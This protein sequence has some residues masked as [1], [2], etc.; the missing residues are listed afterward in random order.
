MGESATPYK[1]GDGPSCMA[2]RF[3]SADHGF[4]CSPDGKETS[5]IIFKAGAARDGYFDNNNI[6]TQATKH[7][8]LCKKY[9][10][11][12]EH[13]LIYDNATTHR[14]R[15]DNALSA[16]KM[17]KNT[18]KEGCNWGVQVVEKGPDGKP[19]PGRLV[20][21]ENPRKRLFAWAQLILKM[22]N[23]KIYI[24]QKATH[25]LESSRGWLSFWRNADIFG[26]MISVQNAR[27]LN[28]PQTFA[29][30]V[31]I[32]FSIMNQISLM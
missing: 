14:K 29:F 5:N 12:E 3:A 17:P 9:W 27:N 11:D 13:I 19:I 4:G 10:P 15:P 23:I 30:A 25:M 2:A 26:H 22:D 8:D 28:A 6:H 18:P 7:M 21:M 24:F 20:L 32:V 16:Q 1:K 31:V